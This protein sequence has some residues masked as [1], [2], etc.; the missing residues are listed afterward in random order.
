MAPCSGP[1]A[2]SRRPHFWNFSLLVKM[3]SL[4]WIRVLMKIRHDELMMSSL[5]GS[6]LASNDYL[7][8]SRSAHRELTTMAFDHDSI[9]L[10]GPRVV[11]LRA[12]PSLH[13]VKSNLQAKVSATVR[14][15]GGDSSHTPFF[16]WQSFQENTLYP[17]AIIHMEHIN[18]LDF[19]DTYTSERNLCF[20]FGNLGIIFNGASTQLFPP[21]EKC[22]CCC[23]CIAYA[24]ISQVAHSGEE[25]MR[26]YTIYYIFFL[27]FIIYLFC[28]FASSFFFF[29]CFFF[30]FFFFLLLLRLLFL[31]IF[32]LVLLGGRLP[33]L[34]GEV[35]CLFWQEIGC[36]FGRIF[37]MVVI[38]RVC[39]RGAVAEFLWCVTDLTKDGS[40]RTGYTFTPWVVSF[41]PP[42]IEHQVGGTSILRLFRM[43]IR[44]GQ[45]SPSGQWR[46]RLIDADCVKRRELTTLGSHAVMRPWPLL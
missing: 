24:W 35:N 45:R 10:C 30:C 26:V 15:F 7:W 5:L 28:S 1:P 33:F 40:P 22:C 3:T 14:L 20:S 38:L 17:L 27:S 19:D 16:D 43:V 46:Q 31:H 21:R 39:V 23:C 11:S 34:A 2:G 32:F 42:S 12:P 9:I 13:S 41:T 4:Y 25:L 8:L 44:L 37:R 36:L 6:R 29:L 18:V